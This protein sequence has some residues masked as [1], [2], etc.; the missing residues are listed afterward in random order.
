MQFQGITLQGSLDGTPKRGG[1]RPDNFQSS[2]TEAVD[3]CVSGIKERF[4]LMLTS[5]S[6]DQPVKDML[7]FNIN[8][9]PT[10]SED[11][12]DFGN[13]AIHHLTNWFAPVLQKAGCEADVVPEEWF[14]LRF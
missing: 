14:S 11:L 5:T 4:D 3:L 9:W 8:S 7:V 6:N 1:A 12:V 2:V 10:S 13:D